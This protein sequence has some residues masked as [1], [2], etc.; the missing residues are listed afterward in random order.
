MSASFSKR[1]WPERN[2]EAP[3][4]SERVTFTLTRQQLE[5]LGKDLQPTVEPGTF[6][7]WIAPSAQAPGAHGTFDL[8][9]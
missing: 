3:G 1:L 8:L 4:K 7:V 6:D 5:F 2:A 9:R